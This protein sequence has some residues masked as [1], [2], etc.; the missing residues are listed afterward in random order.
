MPERRI[1]EGR[2]LTAYMAADTRTVYLLHADTKE[3]FAMLGRDHAGGQRE[4]DAW[5]YDASTGRMAITACSHT[6]EA[7]L[8]L[9]ASQVRCTANFEVLYSTDA[10]P[11]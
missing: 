8:M 5:V 7:S 2:R 1:Y 3:C 11:T 4:W 6:Y 10:T 9:L